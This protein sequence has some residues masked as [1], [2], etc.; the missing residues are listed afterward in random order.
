MYRWR[1]QPEPP[2]CQLRTPRYLA[3]QNGSETPASWVARPEGSGDGG[4]ARGVPNGFGQGFPSHHRFPLPPRARADARAHTHAHTRVFWNSGRTPHLNGSPFT[5]NSARSRASGKLDCFVDELRGCQRSGLAELCLRAWVATLRWRGRLRP[6]RG[7]R[8]EPSWHR[9]SSL[10]DL[11]D[12][13]KEAKGGR[14]AGARAALGA[15]CPQRLGLTGV[16][17]KTSN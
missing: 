16:R 12:R 2:N 17:A 6:A 14:L 3:V 9:P 13:L 4:E 5:V 15:V 7:C 1:R 8:D 10:G 11:P